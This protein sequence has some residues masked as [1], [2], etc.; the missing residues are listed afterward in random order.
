MQLIVHSMSRNPEPPT[1]AKQQNLH[2]VASP[3]TRVPRAGARTW[4]TLWQADPEDLP[5]PR[6]EAALIAAPSAGLLYFGNPSSSHSRANYSVHISRD[7]GRGWVLHQV[8][9]AGSAAYSDLTRTSSGEIAVLFEK[10]GYHLS[11]S[12]KI[13]CGEYVS[14][15]A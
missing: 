15:T 14:A 13:N 1:A 7:G 12:V 9:Y 11:I 10:D 8:V 5:D 6:C 3:D 4:A 2:L